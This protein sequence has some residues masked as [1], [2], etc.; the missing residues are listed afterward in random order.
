MVSQM[1]KNVKPPGIQIILVRHGETEWNR[2]QR[3]QGRSDLPLNQKGKEQ[4]RALAVALKN[5]SIATIYA[6]PLVRAVETARHIIRFHPS[7]PLI[8]EAGLMEMDLGAFEGMEAQRWAATHPDFL[9]AW[10]KNPA[11]LTMPGGESLLEVQ[12]RAVDTLERISQ[13]YDPGNTLLICTHN[14]VIVSLLCYASNTSLNRFR[15][16]K[17]DTGAL[18]VIYKD[19]NHF[20]VIAVNDKKHLKTYLKS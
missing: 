13:Q 14:F 7:T 9:K 20:Q 5:E 11:D 8:K 18:N 12:H 3:F 6:S 19:G 17:Q 2:N 4:A 10:E 15:D 16:W 1:V